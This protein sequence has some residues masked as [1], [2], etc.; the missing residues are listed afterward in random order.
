MKVYISLPITGYGYEE[1]RRKAATVWLN[2]R[3]KGFKPVNP[4]ENGLGKHDSHEKHMRVY[5]RLLLDCDAI[6]LCHGWRKS[7]G[8]LAERT[9][10]EQCGMLIM[11]GGAE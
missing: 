7:K 5:F 11:E 1:R 6:Y 3:D 2:L 9:V 4:M 10:A 8:C